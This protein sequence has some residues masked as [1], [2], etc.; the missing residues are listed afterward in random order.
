M[1]ISNPKQIKLRASAFGVCDSGPLRYRLAREFNICMYHKTL[2]HVFFG[3]FCRKYKF[4]HN[5]RVRNSFESSYREHSGSVVECLNQDRGAAGSASLC[6]VL[7]Q[8]TVIL[9][10]HWFNP[11]RP[12]STK[13]KMAD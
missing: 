7:E 6:F 12:V 9:A 10:K 3:Y 8:D 4:R 1:S 11:G 5:I 2:I 13:L